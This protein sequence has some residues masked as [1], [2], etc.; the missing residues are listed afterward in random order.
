M[1][2]NGYSMAIVLEHRSTVTSFTGN[3][4]EGWKRVYIDGSLHFIGKGFC[5]IYTTKIS[6]QVGG[7][8]DIQT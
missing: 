7:Q 1:Y 4:S 2:E 8:R 3:L 5:I 6:S